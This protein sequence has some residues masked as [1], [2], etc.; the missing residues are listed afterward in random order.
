MRN[1]SLEHGATIAGL[2]LAAIPALDLLLGAGD[3]GPVHVLVAFAGLGL[4][5][6]FSSWRTEREGD[7]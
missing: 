3:A 5:A 4:C 2:L 6:A 1:R 7:A